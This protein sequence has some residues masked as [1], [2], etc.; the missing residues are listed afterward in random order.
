MIIRDA[1]ESAA[2]QCGRQRIG[3]RAAQLPVLDRFAR[4][5]QFVAGRDHHER[6][7]LA[8][9]QPRHAGAG[10]SGNVRRFQPHAGFQQQ[11]ALALVAGPGVDVLPGGHCH[12]RRQLRDAVRDGYA[13]H[14]HH[15]ITSDRQHRAGH[16][17]DAVAGARERERRIA[18]RLGGLDA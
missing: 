11:C 7:L 18:C 16:D 1:R 8:D 13:L 4:L 12:V 3:I 15:C 14:R 2:P 10:C 6:G 5:D 9:T 17:L